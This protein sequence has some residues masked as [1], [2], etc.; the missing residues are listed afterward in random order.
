[1]EDKKEI[2]VDW[3]DYTPPVIN[4]D[5]EFAEVILE[6]IKGTKFKAKFRKPSISI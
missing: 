4:D 2:I 3:K 1:M 6:D 5:P